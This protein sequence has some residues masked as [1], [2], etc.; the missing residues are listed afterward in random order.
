MENLKLMA[1]AA[2]KNYLMFWTDPLLDADAVE[3]RTIICRRRVCVTRRADMTNK[4][5]LNGKKRRLR[6]KA[7]A[8]LEKI[9]PG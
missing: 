6:R 4:V 3:I 2:R 5:A 1:A 8:A 7:A 9:S